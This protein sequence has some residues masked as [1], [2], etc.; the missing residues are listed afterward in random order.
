MRVN[1]LFGFLGSG[2]TT[3]VNLILRFYDLSGGS[4]T[5]GGRD[6]TKLDPRYLRAQV[7]LVPQEPALFPVSI[8]ENIAYGLPDISREDVER[9]L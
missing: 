4:I 9:A 8:H 2:K 5:L 6:L 3:L 7:A 1:M